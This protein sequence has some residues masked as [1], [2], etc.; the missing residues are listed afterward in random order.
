MTQ[1]KRVRT[2]RRVGRAGQGCA[3]EEEKEGQERGGDSGFDPV[4]VSI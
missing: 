3:G 2:G 4:F 1:Q